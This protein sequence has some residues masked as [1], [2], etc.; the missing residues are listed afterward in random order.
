MDARTTYLGFEGNK[1]EKKNLINCRLDYH[2]WWGGLI[3][4]YKTKE[5]KIF[6]QNQKKNVQAN[7][8]C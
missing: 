6:Q 7:L 4:F 5:K 1:K 3:C 8:K 2:F